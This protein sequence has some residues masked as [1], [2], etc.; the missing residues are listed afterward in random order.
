MVCDDGIVVDEEERLRIKRVII[1]TIR[2]DF[3]YQGYNTPDCVR[4]TLYL[5]DYELDRE[6]YLLYRK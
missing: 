4:R 6:F 3:R 5:S 2:V 1:W